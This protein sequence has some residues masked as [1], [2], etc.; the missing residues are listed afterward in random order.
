MPLL[1]DADRPTEALQLL[2][3]F[4]AAITQE[5]LLDLKFTSAILAAAWSAAADVRPDSEAWM[6]QWRLLREDDGQA[7][8][9]LFQ[10]ITLLFAETLNANQRR[11][12]GLPEP[13]TA[14][15]LVLETLQRGYKVGSRLIRPAR[16]VI[17]SAG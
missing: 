4:D 3:S 12:L 7:A 14:E 8:E 1:L 17:S 5:D 15:G 6:A 9:A 13:E 2:E 10:Q 11:E 16:V